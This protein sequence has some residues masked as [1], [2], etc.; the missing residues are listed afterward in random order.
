ML[1][2]Y[3][4][5][6][7][8]LLHGRDVRFLVIGGQ[9]RYQHFGAS[10]RDLDVWVDTSPKN[11]PALDQCLVDWKESHPLHT[12]MEISHPLAIRPNVQLKFPDADALYLRSNGESAQILVEDGIDILTSIGEADFDV[13]YDRATY[14][15]LSGMKIPFLAADDIEVICP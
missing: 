7:L 3:H 9:A 11:R 8:S 4:L 2:N 5:Q 14:K 12:L 10:T 1:N 13:Y 6:F 15:I